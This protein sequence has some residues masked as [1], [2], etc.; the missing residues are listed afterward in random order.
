MRVRKKRRRAGKTDYKARL[1]MLKSKLPRIVFRK[2]NK[3]IILQYIE[4]KEAE[5]K[6]IYG[7]SSKKLLEF[8]WPKELAGSL[9]SLA[10]C[11]LSGLALGKMIKDRYGEIETILDLGLLRNKPKGRAYAAVKGLADIGIKIKYGKDMLPDENRIKTSS[12]LKNIDEIKN[13][14]END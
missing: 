7:I 8:G 1:L 9:K 12:E 3:Y 2:T 6:V 11:Y 14:I 13:K 10:A 4:S 5:D